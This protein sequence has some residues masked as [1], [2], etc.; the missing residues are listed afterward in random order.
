MRTAGLPQGFS[1][2]AFAGNRER[3]IESVRADRPVI[4]LLDLGFSI[5]RQPHYVTIIGFEAADGFFVM[6]DGEKANRIMR[7]ADFEKA[8]ARAGNWMIVVTPKQ[9]R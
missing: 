4:C 1:V 7:Y 8:W 3:L 9:A 5:Y 6:H 2:S